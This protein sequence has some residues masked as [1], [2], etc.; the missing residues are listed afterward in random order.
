MK[1][2]LVMALAASAL[3]ALA[4]NQLTDRDRQFLAQQQAQR[5]AMYAAARA[6]CIEQRG[7]DCVSEQG[8]QEWLLL[9]RTREQAV[10]DQVRPITVPPSSGTGS[11]AP[12]V[13]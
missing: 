11:T 6:R 10:L 5:E 8:L 12:P 4:E 13:R 3:P 7:V 1:L 2:L 9:D